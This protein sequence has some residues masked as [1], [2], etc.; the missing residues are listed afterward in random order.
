[1][2]TLF[3]KRPKRNQIAGGQI[4]PQNCRF[5]ILSCNLLVKAINYRIGKKTSRTC[6]LGTECN[7]VL[8]CRNPTGMSSR[9]VKKVFEKLVHKW[10]F[11]T[12]SSVTPRHGCFYSC[13]TSRVV[14][15]LA[16][17]TRLN[18]CESFRSAQ[19]FET[20]RKIAAPLGSMTDFFILASKARHRAKDMNME[21]KERKCTIWMHTRICDTMGGYFQSH[22]L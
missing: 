22:W 15:W 21:E 7:V 19:L 12:G 4:S 14:L 3:N 13:R 18:M 17:A 2:I 6:R 10:V 1:M 16:E 9:I 8:Y 5:S 11:S 20:K